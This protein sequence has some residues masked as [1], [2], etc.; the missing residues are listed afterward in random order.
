[1]NRK[2]LICV[3]VI[4]S[5]RIYGQSFVNILSSKT[6][7][8][9]F[10]ELPLVDKY[11]EV[12]AIKLVFDLGTKE[13]YYINSSYYTYHYEFCINKLEPEV[14][15]EYFNKVNYSNDSKRK[16]LLANIN[17]YKTL[18]I[19]AIEISPVDLMTIEHIIL[20]WNIVSKTTFIGND[21]HLLLNNTRLQNI[22]SSDKFKVPILNPSEIYS[23]L[24]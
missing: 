12:S 14:D 4:L 6:V 13:V 8:E 3:L 10:S 18:N 21:L 20:L 22:Y 17:Y 1:M 15:L 19:Y 16:Y 5:V 9:N 24:T 11:S 2:F 7:F 23:N